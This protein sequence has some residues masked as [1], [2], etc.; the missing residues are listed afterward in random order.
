M[1]MKGIADPVGALLAYKGRSRLAQA[2]PTNLISL[3]T[4]TAFAR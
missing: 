4:Q 2:L 1:T 3:Q